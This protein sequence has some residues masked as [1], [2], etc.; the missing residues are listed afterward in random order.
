MIFYFRPFFPIHHALVICSQAKVI[1]F[2]FFSPLF[3]FSTTPPPHQRQ[4]VQS[5]FLMYELSSRI[6]ISFHVPP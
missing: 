5:A 4:H 1:A 6:I 3:L 2:P